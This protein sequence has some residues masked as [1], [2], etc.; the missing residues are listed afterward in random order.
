M[1][2]DL[3]A[4]L[5][6]IPEE[7]FALAGALLLVIGAPISIAISR[8]LLR[9]PAS[10]ARSAELEARLDRVE[11]ILETMGTDLERLEGDQQLLARVDRARRVPD[12]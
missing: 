3:I 4:I 1:N 2:P 5:A 10:P 6:A 8:R 9:G 7:A 11:R 12:P